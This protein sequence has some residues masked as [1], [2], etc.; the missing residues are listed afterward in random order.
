MY[1]SGFDPNALPTVFER[2]QR[3]HN[4]IPRLLLT[5]PVTSDRIA[6]AKNRIAQYP[7]KKIRDLNTFHLVKAQMQALNIVNLLN[8]IKFFETQIKISKSK[9][10]T[11]LQYGY[12]LALYKN[13]QF[14]EAT[15]V[16]T[17]L[18]QEYPQEVL[19]QMLRAELA[20]ANKNTDIALGILKTASTNHPNYYP[21]IIQHGQTLIKAKLSQEACDFIRT[22]VRKQP[23]DPGLQRLLAEAYAKNHQLVDAYQAKARAYELE[24]YNRQAL[25]LLQQ[26]LAA[27]QGERSEGE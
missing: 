22:K 2:M 18:Q 23:D 7:A 4:D 14:N 3:S 1:R 13:L 10:L 24:G 16:I 25:I 9:N 12:T 17:N 15:K 8:A 5:H 21:V 27:S 11:A 6:E 20:S 26:A 19:F